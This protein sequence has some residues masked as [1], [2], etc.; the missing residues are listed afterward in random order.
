MSHSFENLDFRFNQL[1]RAKC[2]VFR[3]MNILM[4][5]NIP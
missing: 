5:T 1:S 3:L 4:N 2:V